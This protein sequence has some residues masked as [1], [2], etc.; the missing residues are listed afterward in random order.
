MQYEDATSP[1]AAG[2]DRIL[3]LPNA[4]TGVRLGL[5]PVFWWLL[6]SQEDRAGAALLL[7]TLGPPTSSTDMS[8]VGSTRYPTWEKCSTRSPTAFFS[9][10]G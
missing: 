5:L 7:F 8:P 10:W 3:T 6:F 2:S 1:D 4:I 9:S